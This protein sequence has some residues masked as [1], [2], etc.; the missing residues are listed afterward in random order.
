MLSNSTM[1]WLIL[2]KGKFLTSLELKSGYWQVLMY[3]ADN[4][5]TAFACNHGL[6]ELNVMPFGLSNAPPIF[7]ELMPIVPQGLVH[8]ATAYLDDSL[9]YRQTVD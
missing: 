5:K 2:G 1:C 4:E 7:Q 6:F 9:I 3:E 8:F